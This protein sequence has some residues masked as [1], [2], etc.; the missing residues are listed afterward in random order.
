MKTRLA[1]VLLTSGLVSCTGRTSGPGPTVPVVEPSGS[2]HVSAPLLRRIAEAA[3]GFRDGNDY[4]VVIDQRPPYRVLA[5]LPAQSAADSA[6]AAN[7]SDTTDYAVFGPYRTVQD[8]GAV[9]RAEDEVLEVVVKTRGGKR[10]TTTG[11]STTPS[12]GASLR[13]TS[14]SR[15][16][17]PPCRGSGTPPAAPTVSRGAFTAGPLEGHRARPLVVLT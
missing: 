13:S 9:E 17:S 6:A 8:A 16:I 10:S 3:D 14:S 2:S 1:V 4:F 12:S 15:P 11:R 7:R 5:V